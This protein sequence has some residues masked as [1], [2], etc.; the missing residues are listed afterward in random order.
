MKTLLPTLALL[1]IAGAAIAEPPGGHRQHAL[2]KLDLTPEQR[3]EIQRIRAEGGGREEINAVLT[4]EQRAQAQGMREQKRKRRGRNLESMQQ[5]LDLSEE[6]AEQMREIFEAGGS[7]QEVR[8]VL[9]EE[10]QAK[11]DELRAKRRQE[12]GGRGGGPHGRNPDGGE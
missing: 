1:A 9:T 5:E 4:Q 8:A 10:Q 2:D 6:Q 12:H 11:F 3:E 7:R